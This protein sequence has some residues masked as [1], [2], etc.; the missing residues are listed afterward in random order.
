MRKLR[1]RQ[2]QQTQIQRLSSRAGVQAGAD[3]LLS[4]KLRQAPLKG[5]PHSSRL[6]PVDGEVTRPLSPCFWA[7]RMK[8]VW[9]Q[10]PASA[11]SSLLGC[12]QFLHLSWKR[13]P[14]SETPPQG[15]SLQQTA[16]GHPPSVW[17]YSLRSPRHPTS[18]AY[19]VTHSNL[20]ISQDP[21]I[22]CV[23]NTQ[24]SSAMALPP[25]DLAAPFVLI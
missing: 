10:L 14:R 8:L 25:L 12:F 16:E 3:W 21:T 18:Y 19:M 23:L 4:S 5:Q 6:L 17:T 11:L 24:Y 9:Q 22:S 13:T 2:W 20:D 15:G 7:F 1:L